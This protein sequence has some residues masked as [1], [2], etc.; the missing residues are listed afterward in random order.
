MSNLAS[1]LKN[2]ITRLA[3][4]ELRTETERLKQASA[5]YRSEIAAL[6]RRLAVLEKKNARL[7]KNGV[8]EPASVET[9]T[10]A[11]FS[12][13]GLRTLRQRLGVSAAGLGGLLGVSAQTIYNWEAETTR[14][15]EQQ[16]AAIAA[17]RG[18][19]KREAAARLAALAEAG[20]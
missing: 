2:E 19:G 3:R 8:S 5:Q 12:A 9:A 16:R 20:E 6:K 17:L 1:V 14:P 18:I 10:S 4:K 15:R 7:E 13:K 11:R